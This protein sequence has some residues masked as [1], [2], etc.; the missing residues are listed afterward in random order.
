M[1]EVYRA[2]YAAG[3]KAPSEVIQFFDCKDFA[4][5]DTEGIEVPL[6]KECYKE[7]SDN[8]RSGFELDINKLPKDVTVVRFYNSW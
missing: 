2:C 1:Y 6:T 8:G 7:W 3:I 5:I 4:S